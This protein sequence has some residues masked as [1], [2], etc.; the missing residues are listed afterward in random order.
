MG[1]G[2]II[3]GG[4]AGQYQVQL[5]FS[6]ARITAALARLSQNITDLAGQ[7]TS[8]DAAIAAIDG[9]ISILNAE[10]AVYQLNPVK[11]AAEIKKTLKSLE[12]EYA[13]WR[14]ARRKRDL[15][16]LK[17]TALEKRIE[18]LNNLM[19]ADPVVSAWCADLTEDLAG[20][21][22]TI[23][24]PGERS[25][26]NIMPGHGDAADYDGERDGIL[27]PSIAGTPA[28]VF[29]NLALLPGWQ[30]WMPT[31]RY[32]AITALDGDNCSVALAAAISSAQGLDVNQ[33][34]VLTGVPIEYMD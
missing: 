9:R 8:A 26:V 7:I 15:L 16:L 10:L 17:K 14:V 13:A 33:T 19:P 12:D 28:G 22:G 4:T 20:D 1:K 5:I 18:Y 3:G 24:I 32:G 2:L 34:A 31:F 25:A 6:S 27:E 11:Y 29:Y 30:K 23:E 21:V